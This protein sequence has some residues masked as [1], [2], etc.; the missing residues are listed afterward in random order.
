VSALRVELGRVTFTASAPVSQS[1]EPKRFPRRS[2]QPI[3][4]LVRC[5]QRVLRGN[6]RRS[7]ARDS[8]PVAMRMLHEM[9]NERSPHVSVIGLGEGHAATFG[10]KTSSK[11]KGRP[12]RLG[13][14][15]IPAIFSPLYMPLPFG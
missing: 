11:M 8:R 4:D 6:I 14:G 12:R 7:T 15:A 5:V 2:S 1:A 10:S 9:D 13:S 3:D